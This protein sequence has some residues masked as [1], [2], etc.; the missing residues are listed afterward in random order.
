MNEIFNILGSL[1]MI[2]INNKKILQPITPEQKKILKLFNCPIPD[3]SFNLI[4][5]K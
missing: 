1:R 2:Y 5:F 4:N 3:S